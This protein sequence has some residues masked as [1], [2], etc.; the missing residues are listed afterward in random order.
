MRTIAIMNQKG[1]CGK[2]TTTINLGACLAFLEKKVLVVDLDPQAHATLGLGLNPGDYSKSIYDLLMGRENAPM[3]IEQVIIHLN[4]NLS[5]LPSEIMLSAAEPILL[6]RD[7]REQYLAGVLGQIQDR[8]EFII[9]DCPPNIG[10]LTFNALFVCTEAIIPIESGL[11]SLHG[12]AKLLDTINIVNLRRA[13]KI[14]VTALA[15]MFDRRTRIAHES[16]DELKKY[17]AGN[18]FETLI[19]FNIKLKEASSLGKPISDYAMNSTGFD[20]YLSLAREVLLLKKQSRAR[21]KEEQEFI[22]PVIT[23]DG[24][25]F[26]YYSPKANKVYVVA[27][28]ND[29][30][31]SDTPMENVDGTGVWQTIVPLPS[32][33]YEYKFFVDGQWVSDPD[34]PNKIE[35]EYGEN[36]YIEIK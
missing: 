10:I 26:T 34:N 25:V 18:V 2:T 30:K 20:D 7:H 17:M 21:K 33:R 8:Y 32:G 5:L 28:F 19:N 36:S 23:K 15:T 1:G 14:A 13:D 6:Q 3:A 31:T 12:L 22:R 24:V 35:N 9:I 27:D 16:L 4:E 29:W 11:F